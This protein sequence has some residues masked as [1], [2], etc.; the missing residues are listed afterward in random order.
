MKILSVTG[1]VVSAGFF[2]L[3][4]LPAR[5]AAAGDSAWTG[6]ANFFL[7]SKALNKAEWEPA[8]E[9]GE[10]GV[11]VDF[12]QQDW[13]VGIAIDLLGAYGEGKVYDPFFGE[14]GLE[15]ETSELNLGVRKVWDAA[16]HVRPFIE[17]G[18]SLVKATG[19][20]SM[21]GFTI[22]DSGNGSGY[23]LGGGVYWT[24]GEA[25]NIGLELKASSAKANIFGQDLKVGG[26]HAGLLLGY[27]WGGSARKET[28][29]RPPVH[30]QVRRSMPPEEDAESG[31]LDLELKKLEIER[32]K[33]ELEKA[34]FEFEKQKAEE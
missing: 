8:N 18:L 31:A 12:R 25:F 11:E 17:G 33:L 19:K 32:K 27:H 7:G 3:P 30:E 13:P 6:N 29:Y 5:L 23:W 14:V 21:S 24:L 15:S 28:E 2:L 9:Q 4:A 26:G 20:V 34:K 22:E 1:L 16:P 10:F